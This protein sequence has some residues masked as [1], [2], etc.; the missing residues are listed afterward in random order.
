MTNCCLGWTTSTQTGEYWKA[1]QT[2]ALCVEQTTLWPRVGRTLQ[3][4][5]TKGYCAGTV[6][7]GKRV[8]AHRPHQTLETYRIPT[9][10]TDKK[11]TLTYDGHLR[12]AEAYAIEHEAWPVT[13]T[14]GTQIE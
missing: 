2:V 7:S 6:A 8:K 13:A 4:G 12:A 10:V 9:T 5:L 14:G 3:Q 1:T 11:F